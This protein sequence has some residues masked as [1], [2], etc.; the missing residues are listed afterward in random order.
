MPIY[1]DYHATTPVD[2]RVFASMAPYFMEIFGNPASTSHRFG[3]QARAAVEQ[4][5]QRIA[6]ALN[7]SSPR[8]IVFTSGSTESNNLAIKGV[9]RTCA[10]RGRHVV[11]A[12]TEHKCVLNACKAL[13]EDGF[14]VTILP[15]RGRRHASRSPPSRPRCGPT[16]CSCR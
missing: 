2:P 9:V 16:P 14:E 11:T 7:A 10:A 5:R 8:E 3:L 1:L 4:A 15:G 13:H 12:A 6:A